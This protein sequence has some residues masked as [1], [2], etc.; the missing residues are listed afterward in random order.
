[1]GQGVFW[2]RIM[3]SVLPSGADVAQHLR[4]GSRVDRAATQLSSS[5]LLISIQINQ[6]LLD[7]RNHIVSFKALPR[8]IVG[9]LFTAY[10][11][12]YKYWPI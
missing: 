5:L 2:V 7:M 12:C 1:M 3:V 8:T 11:S 6:Q 9:Y 10:Y 4:S